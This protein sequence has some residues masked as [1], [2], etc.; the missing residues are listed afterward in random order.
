M[1]CFKR[2]ACDRNL[3][4]YF[5]YFICELNFELL[6]IK[7]C[8]ISVEDGIGKVNKRLIHKLMGLLIKEFGLRI[9]SL[10]LNLI[11][12][13]TIQKLNKKYLEHDYSTDVITFDYSENI[14]NLEGEIF[15]SI[16]DAKI[17]A[18]K[19][20]CTIDEEIVRLITHGVL[21]LMGYKDYLKEEKRKI[22]KAEDYI[23][24][25]FYF[26]TKDNMILYDN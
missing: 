25:K 1:H 11:S 18:N 23:L 17:N 3:I 4:I 16:N 5:L 26:L 13:D 12:G 22:K 14:N 24:N 9:N 2:R 7:N 8:F 19:F 10:E 20:R 15:I 6:L 21:H